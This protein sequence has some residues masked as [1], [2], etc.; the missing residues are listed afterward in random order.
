M[1]VKQGGEPFSRT[2]SKFNRTR[3]FMIRVQ[4]SP[5]HKVNV[6]IQVDR[7]ILQLPPHPSQQHFYL[8]SLPAC[9]TGK[10]R[11]RVGFYALQHVCVVVATEFA[12]LG[13]F[14]PGDLR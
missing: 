11:V 4:P 14:E 8:F 10:E 9:S 1:Y 2:S 7:Q 5:I 13:I 12:Q 6:R 3:L